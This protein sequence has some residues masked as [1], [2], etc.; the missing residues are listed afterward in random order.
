[1]GK[2]EKRECV[3]ERERER[4]RERVRWKKDGKEHEEKKE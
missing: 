1:M 3:T 2:R 4:E